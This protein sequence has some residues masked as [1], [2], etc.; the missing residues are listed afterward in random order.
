MVRKPFKAL[1]VLLKDMCPRA[2]EMALWSGLVQSLLEDLSLVPNTQTGW[3]TP[4]VTLTPGDPMP[5]SGLH[6]YV[7]RPIPTTHIQVK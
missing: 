1:P 4:P 2:K 5:F 3:L 7:D 6:G